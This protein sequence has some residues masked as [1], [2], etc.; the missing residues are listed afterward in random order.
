IT[1]SSCR[2][3]HGDALWGAVPRR[4]GGRLDPAA[5]LPRHEFHRRVSPAPGAEAAHVLARSRRGILLGVASLDG[6]TD[7]LAPYRDRTDPNRALA[8]LNRTEWILEEGAI[9]AARLQRPRPREHAAVDDDS[10]DADQTVIGAGAGAECEDLALGNG[11]DH[12]RREPRAHVVG[13]RITRVAARC[14]AYASR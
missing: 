12:L 6:V 11:G 3:S 5:A 10:P 2:L 9:P 8:H 13:D 1:R 14:V 7:A 4:T